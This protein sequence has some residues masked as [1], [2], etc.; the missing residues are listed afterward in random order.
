MINIDP[1][2]SI[3]IRKMVVKLR[4]HFFLGFAED[5]GAVVGNRRLSISFFPAILILNALTF[6]SLCAISLFRS[7]AFHKV[8]V[9]CRILTA[10]Y[11]IVIHIGL[12][13]GS[14]FFILFF[15]QN[16]HW[17]CWIFKKSLEMH[18]I[19]KLS[20]S[21]NCFVKTEVVM[22]LLESIKSNVPIKLSERMRLRI[23]IHFS[24]I[25][26]KLK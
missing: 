20:F 18:R 8:V 3:R 26:F 15:E 13:P 25:L 19:M 9:S 17:I 22:T 24:E 11:I 21:I 7:H 12:S 6:C 2:F 4:P 16:H 5:A 10:I 23:H 14:Y 1:S